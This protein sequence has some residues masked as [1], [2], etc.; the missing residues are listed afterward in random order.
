[1][2]AIDRRR[3]PRQRTSGL[4]AEVLQSRS[5]PATAVIDLSEGGACLDWSLTDRIAIGSHVRL[6]FLLPGEQ[7]S[8]VDGRVVRIARGHAGI[9]FLPEQRE[10][11]LQLLAE[12]RSDD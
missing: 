10:I 9:E 2:N 3:Y 5:G 4:A 7:T 6:R 12:A 1:M 8:E 11:V